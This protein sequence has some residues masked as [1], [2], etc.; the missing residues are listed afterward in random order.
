[1]LHPDMSA[2]RFWRLD[3]ELQML[4]GAAV[5]YLLLIGATL[6]YCMVLRFNKHFKPAEMFFSYADGLIKNVTYVL[7][8]LFILFA[9]NTLMWVVLG[10]LIR[11]QDLIPYAIMVGMAATVSQSMLTKFKGMQ[12]HCSSRL[13][14]LLDKA[15][16]AI[17]KVMSKDQSAQQ[18]FQQEEKKFFQLQM[19][20][21]KKL[22]KL[23]VA[24]A[25]KMLQMVRKNRQGPEVDEFLSSLSLDQSES[26]EGEAVEADEAQK[27]AQEFKNDKKEDQEKKVK[28]LA[29]SLSLH[30]DT[31]RFIMSCFEGF[32]VMKRLRSD[33]A[34]HSNSSVETM[35]SLMA[36][37][38]RDCLFLHFMGADLNGADPK[39]SQE[40]P[41][42]EPRVL[43]L[44]SHL[45]NEEMEK[46]ESVLARCLSQ[47]LDWGKI[48]KDAEQ[49]WTEGLKG[50]VLDAVERQLS[51]VIQSSTASQVVLAAYQ[52]GY[53]YFEQR[54]RTSPLEIF[55][56]CGIVS[57]EEMKNPQ[58]QFILNAMVDA[59]LNGCDPNP[60][61]LIQAVRQT[62]ADV[63]QMNPLATDQLTHQSRHVPPI[64][65]DQFPLLQGAKF[66]KMA[67]V[68]VPGQA[69]APIS[70]LMARVWGNSDANCKEAKVALKPKPEPQSEEPEKRRKEVKIDSTTNIPSDLYWN[71]LRAGERAKNG[72]QHR[73]KE[74]R[75]PPHSPRP[76]LV[77]S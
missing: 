56:D 12:T 44:L 50:V 64:L 54:Y 46:M 45:Q 57:Q 31:V 9:T 49:F 2:F 63:W 40:T 35:A 20:V 72:G 47:C 8:T 74:R 13:S 60:R 67:C 43:S 53:V 75:G 34:A 17:F 37:A 42:T 27:V 24:E 11:P 16:F 48:I 36:A 30:S 14:G 29:K 41:E 28:T 66:A 62:V 39:A 68:N 19:D 77:R 10:S 4:Q 38:R 55:A 21:W 6:S 59:H 22:P 71:L 61:A 23:E 65:V 26:P 5:L 58:V 73:L 25:Q 51:P 70:R 18:N 3:P 15:L 52:L 32:V 33:S 69:L 1:M 76:H 7:L